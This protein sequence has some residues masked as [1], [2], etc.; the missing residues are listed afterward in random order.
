MSRAEW[1][2]KRVPARV[3]VHA[4]ASI[5]AFSVYHPLGVVAHCTLGAAAALPD[6]AVCASARVGVFA[7]QELTSG[8]TLSPF[9][10]NNRTAQPACIPQRVCVLIVG[11]PG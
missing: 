9:S 11:S 8:L 5:P 6:R 2:F 4:P 7:E 1:E 10:H 3:Y